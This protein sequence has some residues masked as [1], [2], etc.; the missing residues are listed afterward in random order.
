V[1]SSTEDEIVLRNYEWQIFHY[2]NPKP[3]A[4]KPKRKVREAVPVVKRGGFVGTIP[5][6]LG[7]DFVPIPVGTKSNLPKRG[8][9]S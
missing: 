6:A 8:R 1:L 4:P 5:L 7:S 3:G 9:L 2:R